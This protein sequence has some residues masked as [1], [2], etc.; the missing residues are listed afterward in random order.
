MQGVDVPCPGL[1]RAFDVNFM[2]PLL[3]N[4]DDVCWN[5]LK[6][7]WNVARSLKRASKIFRTY[8]EKFNERFYRTPPFLTSADIAAYKDKKWN[9]EINYMLLYIFRW[10]LYY[11]RTYFFHLYF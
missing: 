2:M 11:S 3:V 9:N 1:P 4:D 5:R 6:L 8:N 10:I 7:C